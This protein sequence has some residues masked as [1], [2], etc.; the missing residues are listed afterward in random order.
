MGPA[1]S[2]VCQVFRYVVMYQKE[3]RVMGQLKVCCVCVH[4]HNNLTKN[5]VPH[6][7]SPL[8][9]HEYFSTVG[10]HISKLSVEVVFLE[11]YCLL[12]YDVMYLGRLLTSCLE[13]PATSFIRA[14]NVAL[15]G[16]LN[17]TRYILECS[18]SPWPS[19]LRWRSA[20]DRLLGLRVRIPRELWMSASCECRVCCQVEVTATG[21]SL[22][23]RSP[24]DSCVCNWMW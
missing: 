8:I 10:M 4:H 14:D 15:R 13:E 5:L 18:L 11:F 21:R 22:V 7:R 19:G 9:S 24:T 2:S 23:Q 3:A 17:Y 1:A 20:A 16:F 6:W 12:G